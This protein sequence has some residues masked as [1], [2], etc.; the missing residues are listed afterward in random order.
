MSKSIVSVCRVAG[1]LEMFSHITEML[2]AEPFWA[3]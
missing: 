1:I 3:F 2:A